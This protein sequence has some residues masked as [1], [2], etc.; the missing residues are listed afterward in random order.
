VVIG[1]I[2]VLISVLL[3]ALNSARAKARQTQCLNSLRQI[4]IANQMYLN[5]FK[6]WNIPYRWG[7]SASVPPA[8]PSPPPPV[9][10]S[11]P[12]QSW[13]NLWSLGS[14]FQARVLQNG[15]YPRSAICPEAIW[16]LTWGS[17]SEQ[18]GYYISLSYGMNT[19]QLD[20]GFPATQDVNGGNVGPPSYLCGWKRRQVVSSA[21]KIQFV[22]AIGSVATGGSPPYT[23]RYFLPG[24]GEIYQTDPTG[25]NTKSNILAY[26]HNK[27][28]N[29]LF[30]DS[31]C[32]W[33]AASMLKVDPADPASVTANTRQWQPRA[34]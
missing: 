17:A 5:D 11:G 22:D 31:H 27:G 16:A 23:T 6:D 13:P 2:A 7:W 24:W 9:P 19:T 12:A 1:I 29:V 3:P 10:A 14:F 8:P 15:L 34:R 30:F 28:A 4:G 20:G 21:D 18:T 26:R 32:E 25:M 33:L